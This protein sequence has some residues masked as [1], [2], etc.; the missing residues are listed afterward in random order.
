MTS[1]K[2]CIPDHLPLDN[3][4]WESLVSKISRAGRAI[5]R[6][7]GTL[8]GMINAAVLLSPLTDNEAVLSS[9]IEGTQVSL[10]E[11][12]EHEAGEEFTDNKQKDIHEILNYR[13]ALLVAEGHIKQRKTITLSLVR[14]LHAM[15]MDS[16]RG[17]D[18][19]PGKFRDTQNWIGKKNCPI[20]QARFV[21]PDILKM[22][23]SLDNLEK[24]IASDFDDP[25]VQLA[26]IHAQFEIIHPFEDGN[27][28]LGRMMIPLFLYQKKEL[29]RPVFYLSE[30]LESHDDEYRDLLLG[31]T[32]N[33]NWHDWIAFFLDAIYE[34]AIVNTEKAKQ[35]HNLYEQMKIR[36]A[37]VTKSQFAL[38]ALDTFFA[39]PIINGTRFQEKAQIKNKAT[40]NT[41]LK[42]LHESGVITMTRAAAGNRPAVYAMPEL[43]NI[44]EGR[45]VFVK[46][47]G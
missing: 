29:Q 14:E 17:K 7:D 12:L 26:L 2:P 31:I 6:Y 27:G 37:D 15:L 1:K 38:A 45:D 21:P 44:A 10:M 8:E 33:G 25:L 40:S 22:K 28:R 23:E 5:A 32:K 9:K 24:F 35:I 30:Y 39:V 43:I 11:V 3:I 19:S 4:N 46:K 36:F 42:A 41:I 34:Q 18:K 47:K 20:E 13:K 16:V